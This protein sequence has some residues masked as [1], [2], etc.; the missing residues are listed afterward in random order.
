M[1]YE[2]DEMKI[3]KIFKLLKKL[4]FNF[5]SMIH[6]NNGNFDLLFICIAHNKPKSFKYLLK[7]VNT[8]NTLTDNRNITF[9]LEALIMADDE[10][11]KEKGK[12]Y[13]DMAKNKLYENYVNFDNN[14]IELKNPLNIKIIK[15]PTIN[16]NFVS[17]DILFTKIKSIKTYNGTPL[18]DILFYNYIEKKYGIYNHFRLEETKFDLDEYV[19]SQRFNFKIGLNNDSE[20]IYYINSLMFGIDP[21]IF[22]NMMKQDKTSIIRITMYYKVS[23][24]A[25]VVICDNKQK[26]C[27]YY[28]PYGNIDSDT[29][30]MGIEKYLKKYF[31]SYNYEFYGTS[32]LRYM[33]VQA[34]SMAEGKKI[35][36]PGGYCA[37]W[38]YFIAE[39]YLS[40]DQIEDKEN[41]QLYLCNEMLKQKINFT[42]LISNY[43][44]IFKISNEVD[45]LLATPVPMIKE[46]IDILKNIVDEALNN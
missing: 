24:H 34:L 39:A 5:N 33:G 6:T 40:N 28:D 7:Y 8:R 19:A 27:Y 11:S 26:K 46:N 36:D 31:K 10:E 12:L 17:N 32:H 29:F 45:K 13:M 25:C 38:T 35:S 20:E 16:L 42:N 9:L 30:N 15:Y 43:A 1:I 21:E 44:N 41:L 23:S 2:A 3:I 18:Y 37:A 14:I 4:N 22:D